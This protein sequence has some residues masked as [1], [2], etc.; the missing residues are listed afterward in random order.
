MKLGFNLLLWTS[1]V[2]DAHWPIIERLKATGYDGVEIP[3]FEGE[4]SHYEAL[5]KRLAAAGIATSG[6]GVM[7][8]DGKSA[9]SSDAAERAAALEHLKWLIDC[10]AAIG[11]DIC[12]GPFHQPLGEFTG[13]GPTEDELAYCADVHRAAAE[14]ARQYDITLAVEPLNRFECYVLN[15]ATQAADLVRRVGA[16]NY[17]YL[18]DTFHFNIEENDIAGV[19]PKTIAE[20]SHVH[21]SEN[22]RG[23]P[24]AGHI[25][26]QPVF[27]ALKSAGYDGWL[28]IEAFGSA[29]PDLAA[30]TRIWR[31]L[32]TDP[33]D[34]YEKGFALMRDGWDNA[35][36]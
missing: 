14:H 19:I 25:Q 17:G 10:T 34:V 7:P 35:R 26:F 2:T 33:T 1:H 27:D 18:Y 13:A 23:V 3:L 24:G 20:I 6:I 29:L 32:F 8:G 9:V 12:A 28:T 5:G 31:P 11:G 30:A 4:V 22:N 21:I 16:D 15:T 36:A